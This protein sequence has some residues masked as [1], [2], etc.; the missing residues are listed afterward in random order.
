MKLRSCLS[1]AVLFLLASGCAPTPQ[2]SDGLRGGLSC[3]VEAD[4]L[5][6]QTCV[7]GSHQ[8]RDLQP[9]ECRRDDANLCACEIT[10][11]CPQGFRCGGSGMCEPEN[12]GGGA[13][14]GPAAG[15]TGTLPPNADA[16]P[17]DGACE[18]LTDCAMNQF[19]H[20]TTRQCTD[21]PA[22]SCRDDS[23]CPS[24][25]CEIAEGREL[26]RCQGGAGECT[27][28]TDCGDGEVCDEGT[29]VGGGQGC[30]NNFDCDFGQ[31]CDN[32]RCVEDARC[33]SDVQCAAGQI[34]RDM[35][36][37]D[38][39]CT[40]D[41]Q[42]GAGR[43]C[44][45]NACVAGEREDDHGN[46]FDTAT[47]V[48][49]NSQTPGQLNYAG[50]VDVFRFRTTV[51]GTYTVGTT[52]TTDTGCS[53]V[54]ADGNVLGQNDDGGVGSNCEV[55]FDLIAGALFQVQVHGFM[56]IRTGPY[57]MVITQPQGGGNGGG[58]DDHGNNAGG[59]SEVQDNSETQGNIEVGGDEDFFRFT[60]GATASY[61]IS[62]TSQIDT[63]CTLMDANGRNLASDDD[64]GADQNCQISHDLSQ[65]TA[66][67]IKVRHFSAGG[68]GTY[69]LV[70]A[71]GPEDQGETIAE[72]Q[73]VQLPAREAGELARR[74]EDWF[75]FTSGMAGQ[76]RMETEG[77]TDTRCKLL[78]SN[79]GEL[80]D[81][82][83]DGAATNCRI[84]AA[85]EAA[86]TYI[87]AVRGFS[88]FTTG[89]FTAVINA[90]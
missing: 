83:D 80:D 22:G 1:V 81:D 14:A 20:P 84:D 23:Q 8:C 24:G 77:N 74:D 59:A 37:V 34:C 79:G 18:Q 60:A 39:E 32:G 17:T 78:D 76:Y 7:L 4:C 3:E 67:L 36:C 11:H 65:G 47:N 64:S 21:L 54:T 13:D 45:D 35:A 40:E 86:T 61:T 70:I 49:D 19:C 38:V 68:T 12:G 87:F 51:D 62:T 26:G 2:P 5:G 71:R 28:D 58:N 25:V 31:M 27:V 48:D 88:S 10:S 82:D 53:L 16:G 29:C 41:A 15:D 33:I 75:S 56:N 73:A 43:Y 69:T 66:Y 52:G 89:P 63:H 50:D 46:T 9:G 72:A 90:L 55:E 6:A 30:T 42:C 85:L 57:T 44:Q